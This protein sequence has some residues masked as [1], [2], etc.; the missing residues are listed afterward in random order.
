VGSLGAA[1]KVKDLRIFRDLYYIA[2]E[3]SSDDYKIGFDP[4]DLT[5][6]FTNPATWPTTDVFRSRNEI[7]FSLGADQFFPLGDN[8]PES[9]DARSWGN[10]NRSVDFTEPFYAPPYVERDLLIGKA[11]LIYWPHAWNRPIPFTPNFKR[12]G[13]IR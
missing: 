9:Q 4:A 5:E 1:F 11:L 8:S 10:V 2:S 3:G 13:V 7:S 12:M 6:V